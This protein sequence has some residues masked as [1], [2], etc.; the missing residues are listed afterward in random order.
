MSEGICEGIYVGGEVQEAWWWV[1][2][3]VRSESK[4]RGKRSLIEEVA[5]GKMQ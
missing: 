1:R 4:T 5:L 3:C 2:R